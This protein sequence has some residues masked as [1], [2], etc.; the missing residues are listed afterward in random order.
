M[1]LTGNDTPP[2]AINKPP[3][4][5]P[6]QP[7]AN[8]PTVPSVKPPTAKPTSTQPT[9]A[10]TTAPTTEPTTEPTQPATTPTPTAEPTP[11]PT[12]TTPTPPLPTTPILDE[13]LLTISMPSGG[14]AP[15]DRAGGS[16]AAAGMRFVITI[17]PP[18]GNPNPV[19]VGLKFGSALDWPLT[20]NPS[21]WTCNKAA[22][23]C[24][25]TNSAAPAPMPV[26]F[27]PPTGGSAV[28]RTFTVSARTGRLYDDDSETLTVP[29]RTDENLLKILDGKA[30]PD[31]H[32]RILTVA[33]GTDRTSVTLK[34]SYGSALEWPIAASPSGWKCSATTKTCTALTPTRPAPLPA[35][36]AVPSGGS[37]AARTFTV[38]ATAGLVSD[39]DSEVLPGIRVDESLLQII[40]PT[41]QTDPNPFVYNRF[42][43]VNGTATGRRVTLDISWGRNL[44]LLPLWEPGWTCSRSSDIRRATCWTDNY[45][46]PF[47]SEWSAWLPGT[48][49]NNQITVHAEVG[50]REDTDTAQIPPTT[51]R[52]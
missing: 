32:H 20:G 39:T 50:G 29:P 48:G 12:Q 44:A 42:L 23:T 11:T 34:I 27:D 35:D 5:Q 16:Q 38:A 14:G 6:T 7:P 45:R 51:T 18:A 46:K 43:K 36:F 1:A 40:T 49:A 24:T 10:P 3:A 19:V 22:S 2:A 30:D 37:A 47:D 26:T 15:T 13:G 31:V 28:D 25:A 21:G 8:P 52:R 9:T 17:K 33:P 4:Q 41:P